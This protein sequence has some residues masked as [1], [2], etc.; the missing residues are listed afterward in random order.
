MHVFKPDVFVSRYEDLITDTSGQTRRIAAFLGL[1]GADSM[2]NFAA[3]ARKKGHIKTP[4]QMQVIE[5]INAM[6]I[7]RWHHY[8]EYL[9]PVLPILWPMLGQ[10]DYSTTPGIAMAKC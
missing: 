10:W 6:G 5:P 8:R 2:L 1:D 9:E 7:G 3:R 4:S